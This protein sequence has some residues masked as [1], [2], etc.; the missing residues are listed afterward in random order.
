MQLSSRRHLK[1]LMGVYQKHPYR[2]TLKLFFITGISLLLAFYPTYG[3]MPIPERRA[4][5]ILILSAS[6]WMTEALPAFAV[7]FLVIGLSIFL[8]SPEKG[9]EIPWQTFTET[10]S[11]P[12]IWLFLGGLVLARAAEKTGVNK[13]VSSILLTK[14][15]SS[16]SMLLFGIMFLS[17]I[18][19][20][21]MSNTATA[22]MMLGLMGPV[23]EGFAKGDKR[24]KAYIMAVPLGANIGG[25]GSII[26]TPPNAVA[27][28]LLDG[29]GEGVDFLTWMWYGMPPALVCLFVLWFY[30]RT[31][32]SCKGKNETKFNFER[33]PMNK[34]SVFVMVVFLLTIILWCT[35]SLHGIPAS[36]VAFVPIVLLPI[37]GVIE[38][39]DMRSLPWDVLIL[40]AGGLTLGVAV[41]KSGLAY[42]LVEAMPSAGENMFIL[43]IMMAF[44]AC[45]VSNFMSNTAAANIIMPIAAAMAVGY[46]KPMLVVIALASS[47]AMCMPVSTPP[48]ALASSSGL[49]KASDFLVTGIIAAIVGV[50]SSLVWIRFILW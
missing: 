29:R 3:G 6:L 38:A 45:I 10:W 44:M 23:L 12:I 33:T 36:V 18:F 22:A 11:S 17:F 43:V 37:N 35:G 20:N 47:T 40:L 21:F 39:D 24:K 8:L 50:I 28:A 25:M 5:F 30:L 46:E 27:A 13:R 2:D 14:L 32:Y 34:D 4:L 19:S 16:H 48:N 9:G 15:G 1:Q 26:G 42:T 31:T 41:E 7:G 49:L